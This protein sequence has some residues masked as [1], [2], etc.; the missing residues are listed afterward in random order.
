MKGD[1][2]SERAQPE[3]GKAD[4]LVHPWVSRRQLKNCHGLAFELQGVSGFVA[5][6]VRL[7]ISGMGGPILKPFEVVIVHSLRFCLVY[8][9]CLH[10]GNGRGS[11]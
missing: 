1:F 10:V 2:Y 9:D 3:R 11:A 5:K 4:Y 6:R 8:L 7:S